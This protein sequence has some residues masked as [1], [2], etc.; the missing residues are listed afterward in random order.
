MT[1]MRSDLRGLRGTSAGCFRGGRREQGKSSRATSAAEDFPLGRRR[2]L[3]T[4]IAAEVFD[5]ISPTS[6][7]TSADREDP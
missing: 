6:A 4:V 3:V 5:R 7:A 1:R 2:R